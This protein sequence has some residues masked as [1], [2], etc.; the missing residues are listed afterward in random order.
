MIRTTTLLASAGL[1]AGA[2]SAQS[3]TERYQQKLEKE[4]VSNTAWVKSLDTAK[5]KAAKENKLIF[6]YFTRSYAP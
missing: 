6:G 2:L 5:S 1:L 3:M 4:F